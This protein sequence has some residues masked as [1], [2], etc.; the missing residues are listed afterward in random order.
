MQIAEESMVSKMELAPTAIY[1]TSFFS[2]NIRVP[3]SHLPAQFVLATFP[4]THTLYL[5]VQS[6]II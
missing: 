1:Y 4:S 6:I 5:Y 2:R 3:T